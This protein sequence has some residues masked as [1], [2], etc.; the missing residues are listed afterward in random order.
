[1]SLEDRRKT[2]FQLGLKSL[3]PVDLVLFCS[4]KQD[5]INK[6]TLEKY[7]TVFYC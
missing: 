4:G 5:L 2:G 1:M 6:I 7:L 3:A